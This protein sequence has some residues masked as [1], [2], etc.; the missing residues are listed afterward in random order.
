MRG[1]I[2]EE[3]RELVTGDRAAS[4]GDAR[5]DMERIAQLWSVILGCH[6]EPWQVPA[7][8]IALKLS[9]LCHRRKRDSIR[10]IA[11]YADI[12]AL[13]ECEAEGAAPVTGA[14]E[15]ELTPAR[16]VCV[17]AQRDRCEFV[18]SGRRWDCSCGCHAAYERGGHAEWQAHKGIRVGKP[19]AGP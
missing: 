14:P 1:S 5:E 17:A 16:C 19:E 6:V 10:D 7:C 8:M 2:L 18:R 13:V 3:A 11:G 12:L 15:I 9:R 4:Y